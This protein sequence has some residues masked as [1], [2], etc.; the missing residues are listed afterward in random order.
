MLLKKDLLRCRSF[1]LCHKKTPTKVR[2]IFFANVLLHSPLFDNKYSL[3][4]F[5]SKQNYALFEIGNTNLFT[6]AITTRASTKKVAIAECLFEPSKTPTIE[7]TMMNT[8][9]KAYIT[10]LINRII[11]HLFLV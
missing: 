11:T 3:K 7:F 4:I 5:T 6:S 1:F 9:N 2:V 10:N 8:N